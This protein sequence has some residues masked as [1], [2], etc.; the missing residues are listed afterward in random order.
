V[1]RY[2]QAGIREAASRVE[3]RSGTTRLRRG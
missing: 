1:R 2:C 3:Q